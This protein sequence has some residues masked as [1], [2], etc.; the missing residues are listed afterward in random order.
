MAVAVVHTDIVKRMRVDV[1]RVS[2]HE[3]FV[4][5]TRNIQDDPFQLQMVFMHFQ[6]R[7]WFLL[8]TF[9]QYTTIVD[10]PLIF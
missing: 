7:L 1:Q 2:P 5:L 10:N 6:E 8:T 4:N 9:Q 3:T